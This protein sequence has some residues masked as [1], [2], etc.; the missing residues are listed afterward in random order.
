MTIKEALKSVI[1]K[2]DLSR[3]E[4]REIVNDI[5][6]GNA[7]DAQIAALLTAL[8]MKGETVDEI[9]GAAEAMASNAE[10]F[11]IDA[12]NVVDTCGT[13]GDNLHTFN[14]STTAA[15]VA[16]GAG[17]KIAK[18]GNRAVS[19][20]CGSADILKALG[21]NIDISIDKFTSVFN[22]IGLAFLFAPVYHKAMKYAVGP[23]KEMGVRTIFNILG[24]LTNPAKTKRQ[25]IGV[26]DKDLC[27]TMAHVM[28][29]L[30]S[31][32]VMI[33]HGHNGLDELTITGE[34]FVSELKN[35]TVKNYT[36][37]PESVGIKVRDIS[38][39]QSLDCDA[40]K[41][42]ILDVLNNKSG[43][44]LDIAVLNAAAAI[45]VS[46][47]VNN[48]LDGVELAYESVSDGKAKE[49]LDQLINETNR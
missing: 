16:A 31:E 11:K 34:T 46:G 39:I 49:K 45:L 25:V 13:G 17:V 35:G 1:Q 33:I 38:T 32:H 43:A 44:A 41:Q 37:H 24:P 14:I 5:M 6:Q 21:V 27:N 10:P 3:A 9:S 19:S 12:Q 36:I 8:R 28:K 7:T 48:L 20:K 18:H 29:E 40:N 2:N 42:I 26:F 15:L 47:K 23:R 30:G 22:K 4:S